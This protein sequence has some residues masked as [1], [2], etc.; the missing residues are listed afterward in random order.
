MKGFRMEKTTKIET[1]YT[2]YRLQICK[3]R[4]MRSKKALNETEI[5]TNTTKIAK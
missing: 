4:Q 5:I 1:K 3:N 2:N